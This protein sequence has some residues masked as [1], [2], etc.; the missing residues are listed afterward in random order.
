MMDT[1]MPALVISLVGMLQGAATIALGGV[2]TGRQYA[3]EHA[4]QAGNIRYMGC[5]FATIDIS[6]KTGRNTLATATLLE[7]SVTNEAQMQAIT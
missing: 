6:A 3:C 1:P 4:K 2:P 5:H 7:K